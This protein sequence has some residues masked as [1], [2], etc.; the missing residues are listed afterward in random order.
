MM[1]KRVVAV[2]GL[3]LAAGVAMADCT[4]LAPTN[5][6]I[7]RTQPLLGGNLTVGRD[8]PL[9][10]EIYRQ[11]FTLAGD[12]AIS[13]SAGLYNIE[14]RRLLPVTPLPLSSWSGTPYGGRVY[15]TGV[16]GIGVALWYAGTALPFSSSITNCGNGTAVCNW[17]LTGTLSFDMSFIKI[18]DVS[19]GTIQGASLP[20]MTQSRV[21]SNNLEVQH[22][23]FSGSINIVSRTCTTPDVNVPMGSHMLSEFSGPNTFTQWKDFSIALNN[24]PAFNGYYQTTGPRWASDGTISNLDTRKNNVL[25]VR[26]DPTRT[27]LNT[28][29]GI[30]SLNPSAPGD[31]PAATGVGVQVADSAGTALPLASLRTSGITTRAEEGASYSIPLKA[32]YIQTESSITAGPANATATFTINYY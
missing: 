30:L 4:Y 7:V 1:F 19:P 28:T 32:R 8:V 13:C 17:T 25:Q 10:A 3:S 29:L 16:P 27:P 5:G 12:Y 26:L 21:S 18:G 23:N 15:Q 11:T 20:T 31:D 6:S 24:C 22:V 2:A 9:G 14:T